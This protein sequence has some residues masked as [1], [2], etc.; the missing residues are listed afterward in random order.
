M[1]YLIGTGGH[2]KVVFEALLASGVKGEEIFPRNGGG[3]QDVFM[4]RTIG[5]PEFPQ[6]LHGASFHIAIGSNQVR[7]TLFAKAVSGGATGYNVVHPRSD[8]SPTAE[9]GSAVLAASGCIVAAQARVGDGAI[10]NH[11]SVVDHEC[12]IGRFCHIAP[13]AVLG[14]QVTVGANSLIGSGA[15]VLPGITIGRDVTVGAGSTV[16]KSIDDG[17]T[18][19][20]T[21]LILKTESSL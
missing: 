4:G 2:A 7:K 5:S 17:Q 20:G 18:W 6:D 3:K 14:G 19:V 9:L 10:V 1:I 13:G 11:N 16:T 12:V 8:V 21:S 15:V